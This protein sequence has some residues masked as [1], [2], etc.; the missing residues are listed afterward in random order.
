MYR[1]Q[2]GYCCS[3]I[4]TAGTY[5]IWNYA[6]PARGARAERR[7]A[8]HEKWPQRPRSG[9]LG[10]T[11]LCGKPPDQ[12]RPTLRAS[13]VAVLPEHWFVRAS[14]WW[15]GLPTVSACGRLPRPVRMRCSP[16]QQWRQIRH[17]DPCSRYRQGSAGH[18]ACSVI[19]NVTQLCRIS[20]VYR[21]LARD[22][23]LVALATTHTPS[24]LQVMV[25]SWMQWVLS[26]AGMGISL[27]NRKSKAQTNGPLP[28]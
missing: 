14:P 15:L 4:D 19:G 13:A 5:R 26:H 2:P 16:P 12:P 3:L 6:A 25:T 24:Y 1:V 9:D 17:S 8:Q 23:G 22:A 18:S 10:R 28:T 7:D 27:S 21:Q 20:Q 11:D